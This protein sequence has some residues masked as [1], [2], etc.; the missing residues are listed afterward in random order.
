VHDHVYAIGAVNYTGDMPIVLMVDGPS[1]GGFVCPVT[2]VSTEL[3]KMG[4]AR[5]GDSIAF[6]P[7]TLEG[8]GAARAGVDKKV[9]LLRELGAGRAAPG[10]AEAALA[11]F[12]PALPPYPPTAAVLRVWPATGAHP[13][14]QLR[15]AGDRYVFLEYG[16]MELDLALRV[17]VHEL[18][19][20]LAAQGV[21]GLVETSPGVRSVMIEYDQRRLPLSTLVA[22]LERGEAELAPAT[23][24]KLPSRVIHLPMAFDDRWTHEA[25]ARYAR[26][27]RAEAPY[28]PSNVKFVAANNGLEG[29]PVDAVRQV[30]MA[31]SYMVLGLGD[32]YLGAPCAVPLDPRHRL[33]VPKYN[34]ARTSTPEGAVG[35]G[36]C[37]MCIYPMQSP[38]GYQLVG[39]TLPIWNAHCRAG[40]FAPGKPWLLRNF[41]QVRYYEVSEDELEALRADFANGRLELRIEEAVFDVAEHA[42]LVAAAAD[43]VVAIKARQREAMAEQNRI[44]AEQLARM[45]ATAADTATAGDDQGMGGGGDVY[46][47]RAGDAVRAAVTGTVWELRAEVGQVVA[48][49]DTLLVMEAMKMEYAVVAAVAGTVADICVAAGDMVQQGASLCLVEASG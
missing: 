19:A 42:A 49:G 26:S 9:A 2:I 8:A 22:L 30:L 41:D 25:I 48:A 13:G 14:A 37:Y 15:L 20:W 35:I 5:P 38:G 23:Q 10:D 1:L 6:R 36:G 32:V 3:W 43:E 33:V 45:D 28:L 11:A 4:Q 46:A 31:A 27:A 17:R 21:D 34:P 39:R 18:Q 47:G 44:D 40:P 24:A 7:A 12:A 16:P 29:D